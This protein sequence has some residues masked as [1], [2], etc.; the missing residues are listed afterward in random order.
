MVKPSWVLI[1]ALL[2]LGLVGLFPPA[3]RNS[4]TSEAA[5]TILSQRTF[6]LLT[7]A[8]IDGGRLLAEVLVLVS[9]FGVVFVFRDK[10][11]RFVRARLYK[12]YHDD[13]G[14]DV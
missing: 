11:A 7:G 8:R 13:M 10:L 12:S 5:I 9:V 3:S 14:K 6:L 2:L 4:D 1:M